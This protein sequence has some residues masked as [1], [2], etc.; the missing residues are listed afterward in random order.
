MKK[1]SVFD[2]IDETRPNKLNATQ[3]ERDEFEVV[4]KRVLDKAGVGLNALL[5]DR[6][7]RKIKVE[8]YNAIKDATQFEAEK[9]RVNVEL[10]DVVDFTRKDKDAIKN[11]EEVKRSLVKAS[12]AIKAALANISSI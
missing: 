10:K 12:N 11:V 2:W 5:Q 4:R 9:Y 7:R 3:A 6:A 1:L 8:R